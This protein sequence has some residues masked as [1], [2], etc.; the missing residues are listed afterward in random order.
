VC[1][2]VVVSV[3]VVGCWLVCEPPLVCLEIT[4]SA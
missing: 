2:D 4:S 1:L 3:V